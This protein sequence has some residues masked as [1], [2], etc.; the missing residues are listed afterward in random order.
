MSPYIC[1]ALFRF[2]CGDCSALFTLSRQQFGEIVRM[3][4]NLLSVRDL[5]R[6][7]LQGE[8]GSGSG[9]D[10]DAQ[11]DSPGEDEDRKIQ[12]EKPGRHIMSV[13]SLHIMS[14]HSL[15]S[16]RGLQ[17]REGTAG[18]NQTV[19]ASLNASHMASLIFLGVTQSP[20]I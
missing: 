4:C 11:I 19:M 6:K 3:R 15:P 18:K 2:C 20:T 14:V 8:T 9:E 1:Q 16:S 5:F 10:T 7:R 12:S 17:S 13:H